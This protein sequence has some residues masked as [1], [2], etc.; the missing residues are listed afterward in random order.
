MKTTLFL[1]TI[2]TLCFLSSCQ[3]LFQKQHTTHY[4]PQK[5]LEGDMK[6]D[7]YKYQS[8]VTLPDGTT[9]K[10]E[11]IDSVLRKNDLY[12]ASKY[13]Q[14]QVLALMNNDTVLK[15]GIV[16]VFGSD[17]RR[18]GSKTQIYTLQKYSNFPR[19][20]ALILR[21]IS[22]PTLLQDVMRDTA[23][24]GIIENINELYEH[25]MQENLLNITETV[26]SPKVYPGNLR[27]G[28]SWSKTVNTSND[29]G[30]WSNKNFIS[31]YTIIDTVNRNIGTES[32]LFWKIEV[33]TTFDDKI[34]R[35]VY[36]FNEKVGFAFREFYFYDDRR[37]FISLED[38]R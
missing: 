3:T 21:Y 11:T 24:Q 20:T 18:P 13:Y 17:K 15:D 27:I 12:N 29:W 25:P 8:V 5:A 10:G 28:A 22:N 35:A 33:E 4:D 9:H 7:I 34:N 37:I 31:D 36:Y 38:Y 30:T 16:E 32:L 19:D 26:G 14:F 1:I 2:L 23:R 6:Y